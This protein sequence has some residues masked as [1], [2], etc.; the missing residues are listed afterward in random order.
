M[1]PILLCGE[2]LMYSKYSRPINTV[3]T[4]RFLDSIIKSIQALHGIDSVLHSVVK[5]S[6]SASNVDAQSEQLGI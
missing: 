6:V 3:G 5:G 1:E 4:L 2:L